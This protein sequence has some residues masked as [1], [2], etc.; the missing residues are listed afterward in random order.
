V[1]LLLHSLA[2]LYV[3]WGQYLYLA[4]VVRQ[5]LLEF[6]LLIEVNFSVK[7][8]VLTKFWYKSTVKDELL[9][10][11]EREYSTIEDTYT[12]SLNFD[13]WYYSSIVSKMKAVELIYFQFSFYFHFLFDLFSIFL[14]LEHRVRIRVTRSCSHNRWHGHKS[15]DT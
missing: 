14:F 6:G 11:F 15:W 12:Q 10:K 9:I 2:I 7:N 1:V 5:I 4:L 3:K 13:I 8:R